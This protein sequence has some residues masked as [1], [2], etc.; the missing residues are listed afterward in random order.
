MLRREPLRTRRAGV[1]RGPHTQDHRALASRMFQAGPISQARLQHTR[2]AGIVPAASASRTQAPNL[3]P[4]RRSRPRL[5]VDGHGGPGITNVSST[6]T[7]TPLLTRQS[8]SIMP[9]GPAPARTM[10]GSPA[11]GPRRRRGRTT[12]SASL[13]TQP[14]PATRAPSLC[15]RV[16]VYTFSRLVPTTRPQRPMRTNSQSART[17][18][19]ARARWRRRC[20]PRARTGPAAHPRPRNA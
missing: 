18:Q 14:V 10:V 19:G 8:A 20:D 6:R 16:R 2:P 1:V 3:T 7:G 5:A 9:A 17:Q 4:P 11:W 13:R 15:S 12:S